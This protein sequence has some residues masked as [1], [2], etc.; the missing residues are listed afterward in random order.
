MG[1]WSLGSH[2]TPHLRAAWFLQAVQ[3]PSVTATAQTLLKYLNNGASCLHVAALS[4]IH[5]VISFSRG[6]AIQ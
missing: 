5:I 6:L 3:D 2:R 1:D 4:W